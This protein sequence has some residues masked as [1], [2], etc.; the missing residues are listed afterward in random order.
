MANKI[1]ASVFS[2]FGYSVFASSRFQKTIQSPSQF[3]DGG[4]RAAPKKCC[5]SQTSGEKRK[6]IQRGYPFDK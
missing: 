3:D 1:L 4:A 5:S 2:R 6:A